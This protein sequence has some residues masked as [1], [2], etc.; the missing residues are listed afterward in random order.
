MRDYQNPQSKCG[1][2]DPLDPA[3]ADSRETVKLGQDVCAGDLPTGPSGGIDCRWRVCERFNK[4]AV[5]VVPV[6][7]A[8]KISSNGRQLSWRG[9]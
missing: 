7:V 2:I 9:E 1:V 5:R 4:G 6:R 3:S 8:S